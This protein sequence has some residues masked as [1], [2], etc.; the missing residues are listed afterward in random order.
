MN[1]TKSLLLSIFISIVAACSTQSLVETS[2]RAPSSITEENSCT[3]IAS[4]FIANE[5]VNKEIANITGI[6]YLTQKFSEIKHLDKSNFYAMQLRMMLVG[7]NKGKVVETVPLSKLKPIHPIN[8]GASIE[9]TKARSLNIDEYISK[10][11]LPK[12]FNVDIQEETIKSRMLMRAIKNDEGEYIV[13]DGNGRLFALRDYFESR[14]LTSM[15][16]EV[17]VY[18][19]DYSKIKHLVEIRRKSVYETG[20]DVS[21]FR[22]KLYRQDLS[23]QEI[24]E[25]IHSLKESFKH[26]TKMAERTKD[27]D[28][29]ISFTALA[30]EMNSKARELE[31]V[32]IW[33]EKGY[34]DAFREGFSE[35][36]INDMV[37][38]KVPLGFS[39][40]QFEQAKLELIDALRT[41]NIGQGHIVLDGSSTTFYSNNPSKKLGHHFKN[42]GLFK[43]DYDFK[44]YSKKFAE[45]MREKGYSWKAH[46]AHFKARWINK[47]YEAIREFS[48]KWS[49][50]LNKKVTV[51][52]VDEEI[53]EPLE[54]GS[55]IINLN[56]N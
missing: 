37:A 24:D 20:E 10:N 22:A 49:K 18:Q 33:R 21:E 28:A 15:P 26:Y 6:K 27:R 50:K 36:Q 46:E 53:S 47:E 42:T 39:N 52:G 38:K 30:S 13:F 19:M 1:L 31:N 48:K 54:H 43:S 44:L 25:G 45:D 23:E 32:K 8:R 4:E 14:N 34:S 9:K 40:Q 11:G 16:I 3:K 2:Y 41:E 29:R 35:S 51:I 17:E 7:Q 55:F 56:E 5:Q 12:V